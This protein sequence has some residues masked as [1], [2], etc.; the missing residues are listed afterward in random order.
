MFNVKV[1]SIAALIRTFPN[2]E[3]CIK[4]LEN[5]YWSDGKPISPF[6]PTSKVY[7]CKNNRYRCKN[8]GKYFKVTTGTMFENTKMSLNIWFLAIW[9]ETCHKTG[10]S[11]HQLARDIG[12]TQKTAW[13]MLHKIREQMNKANE[14][15]LKGEVEID[16]TYIGGKNKN[17]HWNK[18]VPHSQ[19]RSHKDKTTVVGMIE[20][21]GLLVAKVT[22]DTTSKTLSTLIREFVDQ[23]ATIYTDENDAY[24]QIGKTYK[25]FYVD[26]SKHQYGNGDITSNRIEAAWT[27]LKRMII[28]TYR[29]TSRKYLQ[30]YVDEFVF[31]YNLRDIRDS[32]R[33][34]LLLCCADTRIT[35]KQIKETKCAA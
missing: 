35:Q 24:N 28:G 25:R 5:L 10:I 13:N 32:D 9:Y 2:E 16:E 11:S 18:K 20:R 31:R 29:K 34:N 26:H 6:D 15:K 3:A 30:R 4:H 14:S 17:R 22:K 23:S 12:V 33:F 27:H 19:G 1:N 8:T 7:K 21:N